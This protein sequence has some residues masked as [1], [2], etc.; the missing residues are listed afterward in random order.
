VSRATYDDAQQQLQTARAQVEAA[1]ARLKA[2]HDLVS[3]T[4]LKADAPGVVTAV[5]PGAGEVVQ[6]GQMLVKLARHDGRDAVFDVPS[7]VIRSAP[8]DP[9]ITVSLASDPGVTARGRIREVAP[10]ANPATRT[11]EVKVGLTDPPAVMRLGSTVTG[12]MQTDAA[13]GIEVPASA[14]FTRNGQAAVW[15]V[16]PSAL[17][18][19]MRDIAVERHNPSTVSVSKGLAAGEIVVTAGA[20]SLQAGQKIRLPESQP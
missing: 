19:S 8:A 4:E 10:Q 17:T 14:L 6:A 13:A 5:G 18:V 1:E 7:H 16:D 15:I 11:F 2:A 9:E 12:R 3:F 20:R